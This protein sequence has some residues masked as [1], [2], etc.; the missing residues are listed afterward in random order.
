[1]QGIRNETSAKMFENFKSRKAAKA[2]KPV[3]KPVEE[4]SYEELKKEWLKNHNLTEQD[5]SRMNEL[6]QAKMT[7]QVK[8]ESY[9]VECLFKCVPE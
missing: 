2:A 1:M 4:K 9:A 7:E 3:K 6:W 8:A 5:L